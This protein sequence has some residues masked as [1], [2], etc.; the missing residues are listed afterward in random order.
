MPEIVYYAACSLD[1][2]IATE[3]GGVDWL[4]PFQESG[5]DYGFSEFYSRI[6]GLLMGSHTY[7]FALKQ[8]S[9]QAPE[10]PSWVF[11]HRKLPLAHSSVTLTAD[12]PATLVERLEAE[13]LN[14]LWLMGGGQLA[15]SFRNAGLITRYVIGIV[16]II[17][18]RGLPLFADADR[19]DSLRLLRAKPFSS[20]IVILTYEPATGGVSGR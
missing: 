3:D 5:E 6:D 17:L 10:V 18:G 15:A 9:W 1:G 19:R 12:E 11:T 20:G 8:G 14:R 13:G 16:P 4:D 7:E 2:F